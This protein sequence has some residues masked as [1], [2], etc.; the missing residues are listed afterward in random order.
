MHMRRAG[1]IGRAV[2][3]ALAVLSGVVAIQPLAP[4]RPAA[5]EAPYYD[6]SGV[7]GSIYRLYR[8]YFLREPDVAGLAYWYLAVAKGTSLDKVSDVFAASSEFRARYG[9]LD[10]GQFLARVYQN[11]LGRAPDPTGRSYWVTRLRAGLSRGR[12]MRY[13]SESSEY[14]RETATGVPPGWR[15]GANAGKLLATL[16]VAAESSRAG[17][18]E[19]LFPHWDDEDHDGCD[20]RCEVL[21]AEKRRDGTWFS[22]WDAKLVSISGYLAVDEVVDP[23]EAWDSG[24]SHWSAAKR[25]A[26]ADWQD[27]LV[28]VGRK[29]DEAKGDRD[30]GQWSPPRTRSNCLFAEITVTTKARWKLSV[31]P[32]EKAKLSE[33]LD[34][35]RATTSDP[36][37]VTAPPPSPRHVV[38]YGDSLSMETSKFFAWFTWQRRYVAVG[39]VW[40]GTAPCDWF[41]HMRR[42]RVKYRPAVVVMQFSGANITPC[43]EGRDAF[44][45]YRQ[46]A[47]T[48]T[49]I[50]VN[51][52]IP[53]VWVSTPLPR[54]DDHAALQAQ[55][56][57]IE[58]EAATSLGETY[59]DAGASVLDHGTFSRTLPC[60]SFETR[61]EGC[62]DGRIVVRAPDGGHLCPT[63]KNFPCPVYSSGALRYGN[64]QADAA[65]RRIG[66]K[67]SIPAKPG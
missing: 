24:A 35:C 1:G 61:A 60:L 40:G 30:A 47:R 55:F 8:A 53:V 5:A 67:R 52:G 62:I 9:S 42:D 20:T 51:A 22:W 39:E 54:G 2:A 26:F 49:R 41:S 19:T 6:P 37:A 65:L 48:A 66:A 56:N 63:Q 33:L 58:R 44:E 43:M 59:V 50:F 36:P 27:N 3:A 45:A 34:G 31:D 28:V 16:P 7:E 15:A 23:A 14:R 29:T 12:V 18:D 57:Q 17:Y 13:F 11:V 25:D 46:D 10:D 21:A 38:I 4:S 32:T 64:A